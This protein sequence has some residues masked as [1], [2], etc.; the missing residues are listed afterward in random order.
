MAEILHEAIVALQRFPVRQKQLEDPVHLNHVLD[1]LLFLQTL[2][3]DEKLRVAVDLP[4]EAATFRITIVASSSTSATA[5]AEAGAAAAEEFEERDEHEAAESDMELFPI[6]KSSLHECF[7]CQ[8]V[9]IVVDGWLVMALHTGPLAIESLKHRLVLNEVLI[10]RDEGSRDEVNR[11]EES[12][13]IRQVVCNIL[14]S[15]PFGD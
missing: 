14:F 4:R 15:E 2:L 6:R 8:L 1:V 11:A 9:L 12:V 7:G 5:I 10:V 3:S 13:A